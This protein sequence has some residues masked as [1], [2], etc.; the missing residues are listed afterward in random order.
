MKSGDYVYYTNKHGE[1]C[2][3]VVLMV[4]TRIKISCNCPD[5]DKVVWVSKKNLVLQE[6]VAGFLGLAHEMAGERLGRE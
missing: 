4:K 1:A 5:G 3:G 2:P 6:H